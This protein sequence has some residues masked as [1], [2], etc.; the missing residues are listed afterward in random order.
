MILFGNGVRGNDR[1]V[2]IIRADRERHIA[3]R[4]SLGACIG[5]DLAPLFLNELLHAKILQCQRQIHCFDEMDHRL[6]FFPWSILQDQ[7]ASRP[8]VTFSPCCA[9][10]KDSTAVMPLWIACAAADTNDNIGSGLTR[11]LAVPFNFP[12]RD[13]VIEF[14]EYRFMASLLNRLA[15]F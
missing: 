3:H 13:L 5:R 14:L 12:L 2:Y 7:W 9:L 6:Q 4:I 15:R 11:Q 8:K 10:C 1:L